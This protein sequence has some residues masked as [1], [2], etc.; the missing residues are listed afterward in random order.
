M[1]AAMTA[2]RWGSLVIALTL[3]APSA[4]LAGQHHDRDDRS[5]VYVDQGRAR[6]SHDIAFDNGYRDGLQKGREAGV[7][8]KA[9]DPTHTLWYRGASRGYNDRFGSHEE[10]R[11]IYRDGFREGY[12]SG[13]GARAVHAP[14]P[15]YAP[16]P[17]SRPRAEVHVEWHR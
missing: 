6:H 9:F 5:A 4:A 15:V 13:Y 1:E 12:E 3:L 8:R 10:Y 16:A 17:D 2:A 11:E 14:D 7:N